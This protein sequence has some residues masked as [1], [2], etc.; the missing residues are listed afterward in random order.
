M[1]IQI[2]GTKKCNDTKKAQR[3]YKGAHSPGDCGSARTGA[4]AEN[5]ALNSSLLT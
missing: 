4:G 2:F 5:V 3:Y 1:N